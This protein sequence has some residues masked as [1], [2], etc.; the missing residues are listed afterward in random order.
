[1]TQNYQSKWVIYEALLTHGM[2]NFSTYIPSHNFVLKIDLKRHSV[3]VSRC[4][5]VNI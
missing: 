4:F 5:S 1:L 2:I 3:S